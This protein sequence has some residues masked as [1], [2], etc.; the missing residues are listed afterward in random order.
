MIQA[1]VAPILLGVA[2]AAS[3]V[4]IAGMSTQFTRDRSLWP[5]PICPGC[6]CARWRRLIPIAGPLLD[7]TT[8]GSC[9]AELSRMPA[10]LVQILVAVLYVLLYEQLGLS[11]RLVI[12]C[13]ETALLVSL[14]LVD[15]QQRLIPTLLVGPAI[16]FA[17]A[18]S[19]AWPNLGFVQSLL[20][21]AIGFGLFLALALFARFVFGE[22]ALGGGDVMLAGLIGAMCGYPLL[23]LALAVGALFGGF[24]AAAVLVLRRSAFGTA[25]PY[26]PYLVGGVLYVMLSGYLVHSPFAIP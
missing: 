20:G 5:M 6:G 21:G 9:G 11:L 1:V 4:G 15:A 24:G 13:V 3:G 12:S 2:G 14:A 22:G 19:P 16:V 23:I 10:L 8:C 25:I 26:G 7:E 17:I 18:V